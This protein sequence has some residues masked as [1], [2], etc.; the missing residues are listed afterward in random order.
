MDR[1]EFKE[2]YRTYERHSYGKRE[3]YCPVDNPSELFNNIFK[4][5]GIDYKPQD[6]EWKWEDFLD[7]VNTSLQNRLSMFY[8]ACISG[9]V[10]RM[11]VNMYCDG[12][13]LRLCLKMSIITYPSNMNTGALFDWMRD[14][15]LGVVLSPDGNAMPLRVRIDDRTLTNQEA[16]MIASM[17]DAFNGFHREVRYVIEVPN[18]WEEVSAFVDLDYLDAVRGID[19]TRLAKRIRRRYECCRIRA[20]TSGAHRDEWQEFMFRGME[21]VGVMEA[22]KGYRGYDASYKLVIDAMESIG[23]SDRIVIVSGDRDLISLCFAAHK[24]AKT[25]DF[26]LPDEQTDINFIR[27]ADKVL[28]LEL[29]DY[30][31]EGRE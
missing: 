14:F 10:P 4:A 2:T 25:I 12:K 6:D 18:R 13:Q 1:T 29:N 5:I 28:D 26:I 8:A 23:R 15:V 20:Y 31:M 9:G 30:V 19:Y 7:E 24:Q 27:H 3:M 21:L 16:R 11:I 17:L 22:P